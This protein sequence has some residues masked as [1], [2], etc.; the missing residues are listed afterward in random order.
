MTPQA[1]EAWSRGRI[2]SKMSVK[3]AV[4]L[5]PAPG[6]G[7]F[8]A[9]PNLEGDIELVRIGVEG[10][11]LLDRILPLETKKARDPQL[12][13]GLDGRLHLLWRE[14]GDPRAS[15]RYALLEADGTLVGRPQ[16]LSDPM[17]RA[18]DAPRLARDAKGNVYA[19]WSDET[20]IYWA[21]FNGEGKVQTEPALLIPGGSSLLV[22]MDDRGR[23]HLLW[24]QTVRGSSISIYYAVLDLEKG[25][26]G[27]PE[28]IVKILIGG[29]LRLEDMALGLSQDGGYVFWS[30]YD[31]KY[32]RYDFQYAFF[33]LHAP[34]QR[35]INSWELKVGDGP[36]SIA[37]LDGQQSPLPVALSERMMG[38]KRE[39]ELQITLI[40][41][42]QEAARE[43]VVTASS[44]A[45]MKPVLIA[46]DRS[47]LHMAWLETGGFGEYNV[48]YAS[49]VPE[50]MENYN[51]LT[52]ID[53]LN[54][55]FNSV[56]RYSMV[57][58]SLIA[59]LV[60]WAV[61][62][63]VGLAVYHVVTNEETLDTVRSRVAIITA[64]VV[65]VALSFVFPPRIGVG[66]TWPAALWVV[67]S[68][69]ALVATAITGSIVRR[70]EDKHLFGTFFLFTALNS[71]LQPLLY[72]LL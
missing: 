19:L 62:P 23:L 38:A 60:T 52:F 29:L 70:Q 53:V 39:I 12:Q 6:G 54:T 21:M 7:V 36:L 20:G 8:L 46:D 67:P 59:A 30:Y 41:M 66:T 72:F 49:T 2:I 33:P 3:R 22:Q 1:S 18:S 57:I 9:W 16:C 24:Q 45:S 35:R 71:L 48:V 44:Q 68:V 55:A 5:Q 11:V 25:E 27:N 15:V 26:P 4:T 51:V 61:I 47:Y 42:G 43:Q 69:T 65:E 40:T 10:E 34:Q 37:P 14:Q 63:L 32:D 28:E 17:S 56:F 50:V 64:L 13:V 58:L 31:A